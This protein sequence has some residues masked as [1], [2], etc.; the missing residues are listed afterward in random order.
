MYK[1]KPIDT[2]NIEIPKHLDKLIELLSEN[3]HNIWAKKRMEEGWT[4]GGE[5]NDSEKKHPDLIPYDEL[6]KTERDY[7][8]NIV[9]G[10]IKTIIALG[11]RI[12]KNNSHN[13]S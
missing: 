3:T 13:N 2:D 9:M 4:F 5:R 1:P 8:R 10:V 6:L 7:D 11:Y 12:E